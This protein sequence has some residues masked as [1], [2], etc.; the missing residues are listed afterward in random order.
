MSGRTV[1]PTAV[2]E[3]TAAEEY[4]EASIERFLATRPV[5]TDDMRERL[6]LRWHRG[7][8]STKSNSADSILLELELELNRQ[9]LEECSESL[10][11]I[12]L[13]GWNLPKPLRNSNC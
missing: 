6:G 3:H 11:F 9:F 4:L 8:I 7:M 12:S 1:R 2:A 13:F 10:T 5:F